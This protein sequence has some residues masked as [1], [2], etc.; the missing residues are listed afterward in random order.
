[1]AT[2]PFRHLPR[3]VTPRRLLITGARGTVGSALVA[4]FAAGH[5]V[6]ACDHA[7]LD[8]TDP[9]AVR[10][11]V[12]AFRPHAILNPA[13]MTNVDACEDE[14][15]RAEAVN[16]RAPG[17]L[18]A[19]AEAVGATLVHFSTDYVFDGTKGAPYV[20]TDPPCPLG[21]YGR[22]KLAGE[23]AVQAECA[24]GFV[25]RVAWVITFA[26]RNFYAIMREAA[27]GGRARVVHQVSSP[28]GLPDISQAVEALLTGAAPVGCYH[29]VNAGHCS[30]RELAAEIFRLLGAT[31]RIEEV[32]ATPGHGAPR[33]VCSPLA[34]A[35]WRAAGLPPF[36][37][38]QAALADALAHG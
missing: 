25:V 6:L 27:A 4:H 14:P 1:M 21:V 13:A 33:P 26:R 22:T 34:A 17:Y 23:L 2:Q 7:R 36:R 5:D 9:S 10:S 37:P 32:E 19:A 8:I 11:L 24:R 31:V 3:L 38:W 12:E 18:A 20:E 16:A 28:S 35:A 30:R 29:L 15:E